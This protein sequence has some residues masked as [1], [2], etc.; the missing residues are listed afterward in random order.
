MPYSS[1]RSVEFDLARLSSS[2]ILGAPE[3][4]TRENNAKT[5]QTNKMQQKHIPAVLQENCGSMILR[6]HAPRG[7]RSV[8]FRN[9]YS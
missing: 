1:L 5:K 3:Y 2:H 9:I 8:W 4:Y 7:K 6:D